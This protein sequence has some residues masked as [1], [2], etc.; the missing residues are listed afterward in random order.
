MSHARSHVTFI[1][2]CTVIVIGLVPP[3]G[4]YQLPQLP[5]GCTEQ[6]AAIMSN[7]WA[8]HVLFFC[9]QTKTRM[10]AGLGDSQPI[11]QFYTLCMVSQN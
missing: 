9:Q 1:I 10:L 2:Q 3:I 5:K 4:K 8:F 6:N 11:M 7:K